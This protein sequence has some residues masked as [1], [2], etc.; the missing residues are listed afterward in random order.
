[1][2]KITIFVA[3]STCYLRVLGEAETFTKSETKYDPEG[4][5]FSVI[6]EASASAYSS[7]NSEE[8]E[9]ILNSSNYSNNSN[10]SSDGFF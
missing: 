5:V 4:K 3:L 10:T 1:M 8:N 9:T 2:K 7:N 6:S